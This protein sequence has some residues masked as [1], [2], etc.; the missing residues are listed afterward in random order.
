MISSTSSPADL[1][2]RRAGARRAADEKP[3]ADPVEL[4]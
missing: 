1:E 4:L 3:T 2:V